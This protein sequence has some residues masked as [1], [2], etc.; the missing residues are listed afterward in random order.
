MPLP[1]AKIPPL[2]LSLC[3]GFA[4]VNTLLGVGLATL[5]HTTV[6]LAVADILTYQQ[7]GAVFIALGLVGAFALTTNRTGLVRQ[8]QLAN[9]LVKAVWLAA[10]AIRCLSYPQTIIITLVWAFFAYVQMMVYI[11]FQTMPDAGHGPK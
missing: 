8:T 2:T 4:V 6:P 1:L 7:W 5:Y 9:V 10:L 3:W 11:H